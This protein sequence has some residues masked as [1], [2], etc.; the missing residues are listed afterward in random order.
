VEMVNIRIR[1]RRKAKP[2][3]LRHPYTEN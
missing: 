1:G 2:V 3:E